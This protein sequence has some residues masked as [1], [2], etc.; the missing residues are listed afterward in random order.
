[1][2]DVLVATRESRSWSESVQ[3]AAGFAAK[4]DGSLTAVYVVPPPLVLPDAATMTFATELLEI[5]REEA[6][7]AAN[8]QEP[9]V[10]WCRGR[11]VRSA[12]W[13]VAEG[14][15]P[16]VLKSAA[17]WAD[18]VV[19]DRPGCTP[20]AMPIGAFGEAALTDV[21][22]LVVPPGAAVASF[23]TAVVA[24]KETAESTRAL[25]A[26]LPALARFDRVVVV[27]GERGI[28]PG[29]SDESARVAAWHLLEHGIEATIERI[30]PEP[31][32]A[33]AAI[34]A[35]ARALRADLLVM[36]AYGRTRFSEWI[37]GG[38]TRHAL[39]HAWLPVFMR[40]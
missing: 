1:M 21:P 14:N 13:R 26:A 38:A 9:F 5:E 7:A 25:H 8:A 11:G 36:G 24:W 35:A 27:H 40:H 17:K 39:E 23:G 29:R 15:E 33:G 32:A 16:A 28:A 12:D 31:R 2:T 37:F 22:C 30:D 19:L 4:V 34:L 10:R 3:Y 18:V 6:R 20:A